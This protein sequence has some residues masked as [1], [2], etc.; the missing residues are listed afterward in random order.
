M[1]IPLC[2]PN[3]GDEEKEAVL[4]VL[5]SGWLTHGPYNK[6]FEELFRNKVG[7]EHAVTMNSCTSAL[8]A[9]IKAAGIK[10]E[11]I[12]PAF[13]W[14]A[15]A[16]AVLTS[17]AQ[18]VFADVDIAT[19]NITA[20]HIEQVLS[21]NTEAVMVVHYGG[22]CCDMD[23]I[24]ALCDKHGLLLIEDSAETLGGTWNGKQAGSFGVGCFS[25][26]PT[27]NITTGDGGMLTCKDGSF[28]DRVKALLG[29]GIPSQTVD[30]EGIR[31]PWQRAAVVPG[32][33]WRLSNIQAAVGYHQMLK[34]DD[35][36]DRRRQIAQQYNEGIKERGLQLELPVELPNAKHVYQMYTVRTDADARNAFVLALREKGVGASVHFDPP[37]HLQDYYRKNTGLRV[38]VP[39][40]EELSQT[41][42]TLP[43]FPTMTDEQITYVLDQMSAIMSPSRP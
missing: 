5:G 21:P 7:V 35:M 29:H 10:G 2:I 12:V 27:K 42:V 37:V 18:L 28:F 22:Q 39:N 13:T 34:L 9:T 36:N 43:M 8:E 33:N 19:R 23:P 26:F 16:N 11:V 6:K 24:V 30:R 31:Q 40:S 32:H 1:D 41:L 15:S 3:I 17:G 4:E 20:S 14:V 38:P 25:F